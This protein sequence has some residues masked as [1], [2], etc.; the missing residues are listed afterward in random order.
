MLPND[1]VSQ[2]TQELHEMRDRIRLEEELRTADATPVDA[3]A[4]RAVAAP[5]TVPPCDDCGTAVAA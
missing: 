2:R 5:E 1:L 4:A 3:E